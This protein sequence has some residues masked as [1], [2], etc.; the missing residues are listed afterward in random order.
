MIS[1][2]I[3]QFNHQSFVDFLTNPTVCP[4]ALL[5]DIIMQNETLTL[6]SLQAMAG[7]EFNICEIETS[8]VRNDEILD[9]VRGTPL[10]SYSLFLFIILCSPLLHTYW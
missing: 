10:I 6:A 4:K 5:V 2:D 8:Y 3:L 1:R 9:F 7:L